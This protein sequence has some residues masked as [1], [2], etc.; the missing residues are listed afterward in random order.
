MIIVDKIVFISKSIRR[1]TNIVF[2]IVHSTKNMIFNFVFVF[3]FSVVFKKSG[4]LFQV[5][6][7]LGATYERPFGP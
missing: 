4:H 6:H 5:P 2:L 3:T 7:I 1:A